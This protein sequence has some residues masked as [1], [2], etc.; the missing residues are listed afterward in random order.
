MSISARQT[1]DHERPIGEL[2]LV[3]P[4]PML[5][6]PTVHAIVPSSATSGSSGLAGM[7]SASWR[8]LAIQFL[9]TM[10]GISRGSGMLRA[11]RAREDESQATASCYHDFAP[12]QMQS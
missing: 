5:S 2:R 8:L 11:R 1:I 6:S 3:S 4:V 7:S 10:V 9:R 12:I